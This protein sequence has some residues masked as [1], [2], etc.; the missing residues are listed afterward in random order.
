MSQ[1]IIALDY[2][3][4][5]AVFMIL[6]C[7]Y[8]LFSDL[9]SGIGRYLGGTGNIIF[10]VVSALLYGLKYHTPNGNS[11]AQIDCYSFAIRRCIKLGS[12]VWPFLILLVTFYIIYNV[13]FSWVD[14]SLNFVFLGYLGKLPGNGHLWFL[15]ILIVCYAEML[16]LLKLK[17]IRT[18][19]PWLIIVSSVIVLLIGEKM[20]I[21]SGV[22]VA[23]GMFGFVFIK[24]NWI[25]E[26]SKEM[27]WAV[28]VSMI[29]LNVLA[30]IL[31][32]NGLF[33]Y[34]RVLHFLLTGICGL[35][36]LSVLLKIVP[37]K[38]SSVI[39]FLSGISFE[40]YI[41]HHTMCAGP[42]FAITHWPFGHVLNFIALV[43]LSIIIATMLNFISKRVSKFLMMM[44]GK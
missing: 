37:N 38:N 15:T 17:S 27:H 34:S 5:V 42:F 33:G 20:G 2:I 22:F 12:S 26:K 41:V 11:E 35:S 4:V 30:L 36:L 32:Y 24:G 8:F 44:C 3:R 29:V 28:A 40:T 9:S 43:V 10:F 16:L 7:H 6:L 39:S 31:E 13:D 14:V 23:I 21:P 19:V 1:R 18:Y 25:L